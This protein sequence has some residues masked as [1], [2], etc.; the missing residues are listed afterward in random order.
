MLAYPQPL[1]DRLAPS[2]AAILLSGGQPKAL[3]ALTDRIPGARLDPARA[4]L[5]AQQ[6]HTTEALALLDHIAAGTDRRASALAARQAVEMRL[7][8]GLMT[9]RQAAD[10]LEKQFYRWRDDATELDLRLRVAAL[11]AQASAW[12]AALTMLREASDA[13]PAAH[14][15]VA[16]AQR[17]TL[18]SLLHAGGAAR[19]APIDLVSL[20]AENADLLGDKTAS[21]TLAPVLVDKLLELDLPDRAT[22]LLRQLMAATADP[23]DKAAIGTRLA[24]LRLDQSDPPGAIAALDDSAPA[25]P[26][27]AMAARRTLLRARAL[28]ADRKPEAALQLLAA[29]SGADAIALRATLREQ[30]KDWAGAVTELNLLATTELPAAAAAQ[31]VL[32]DAQQDLVLRLASD[33]A[34]A[35]DMDE[36]RKLQAGPARLMPA[37]PHLEL[38]RALASQPIRAL[39]DLPRAKA[40]SAAAQALPALL[41]SYK[42][43]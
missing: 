31:T 26:D 10:A 12:R 41:A 24:A 29:E 38:F 3:A 34:Q 4:G 1:R 37:G 2:V 15:R 36:L 39:T 5:L 32:T 20:I 16:Q 18:G 35:G 7:A 27:P 25:A 8:A 14:D 30:A 9:P 22:K 43:H 11:D 21:A 13:F 19:M 40:E 42:G 17:D 6:G 28:A 33:A 23:G